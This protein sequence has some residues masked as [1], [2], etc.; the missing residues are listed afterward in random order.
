MSHESHLTIVYEYLL[1]D[2]YKFWGNA[3]INYSALVGDVRGRGQ[4]KVYSYTMI[5]ADKILIDY[6]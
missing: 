4:C 5:L 6:D 1:S 3:M 2:T